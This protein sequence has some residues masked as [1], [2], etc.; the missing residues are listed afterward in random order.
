MAGATADAGV[1]P[2]MPWRRRFSVPG[3]LG[4]MLRDGECVAR[5]CRVGQSQ[6]GQRVGSGA[7]SCN[8]RALGAS[9]ARTG[10]VRHNAAACYRSQVR[11]GFTRSRLGATGSLVDMLV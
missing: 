5:C 1:P 8:T 11:L 10:D 2:R 3:W 4:A 7:A 9:S 6:G